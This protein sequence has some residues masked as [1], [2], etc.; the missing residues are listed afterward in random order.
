MMVLL[1]VLVEQVSGE[2][3]EVEEQLLLELLVQVELLLLEE[4]EE[5]EI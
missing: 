1:K 2:V 4:Q 5:Q 3:E